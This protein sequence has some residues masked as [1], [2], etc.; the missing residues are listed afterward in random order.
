MRSTTQKRWQ[1]QDAK[2]RLSQVVNE[3]LDKGP[4]IITR[5]GKD[6]AAVIAIDDLPKVLSTHATTERPG[7]IRDALRRCPSPLSNLNLVR[8]KAPVSALSIFGE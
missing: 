1:L 7:A 3:T 5:H 4:Q 8:D 2:A 6:V